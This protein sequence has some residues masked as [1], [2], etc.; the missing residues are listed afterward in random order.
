M[1]HYTRRLVK[2]RPCLAG[3]HGRTSNVKSL[4]IAVE[5]VD[6]P[7]VYPLIRRVSN[8]YEDQEDG[9]GGEKAG[10]RPRAVPSPRKGS[11]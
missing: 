1:K 9:N 10:R 11:D 7:D 2:A 8:P 4:A 6:L 3:D 5:L